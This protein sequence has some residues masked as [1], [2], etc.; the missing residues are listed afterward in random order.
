MKFNYTLIKAPLL[1]IKSLLLVIGI[2]VLNAVLLIEIA[3]RVLISYIE[4]LVQLF[5]RLVGKS[6]D[7]GALARRH[8][9]LIKHSVQM[10]GERVSSLSVWCLED[11]AKG[12][13][14]Q[15]PNPTLACGQR[16]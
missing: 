5:G 6:G 4:V 12:K 7:A 15:S 16:E 1:I 2:A 9:L 3:W 14:N 8:L 10:H 13:P 11:R